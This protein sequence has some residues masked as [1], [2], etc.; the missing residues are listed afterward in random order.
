MGAS[1]NMMTQYFTRLFLA[2]LFLTY[3]L[4]PIGCA[5]HAARVENEQALRAIRQKNLQADMKAM[6][7]RTD[8]AHAGSADE[9]APPAI[10]G[11]LTLEDAIS[12]ALK[13]NLDAAVEELRRDIQEEAVV[14]AR[15]KMLPSLTADGK[16]SRRDSY[17]ASSS[18]PLFTEGAQAYN[19]S[20]DKRTEDFRL[21]LSW[22]LLDFGISYYQYRQDL[23][24]VSIAEQRRRRVIQ[25]LKFNVTETFWLAQVSKAAMQMAANLASRLQ[26]RESI[27]ADQLESRTVS[28]IDVLE[29]AAA[30]SEMNMRMSRF[31]HELQKH[32]H[33]L[34]SLMGMRG[35][36]DFEVAEADFNAPLEK[37]AFR[38]KGL[39][40]TA[41]RLRPELFE[42][43]LEELITVDDARIAVAKM[44]PSASIFWRF[45][46]DNDSHLYYNDWQDVGFKVSFDL[47]SVPEKMSRR[48]EVL[49]T[50]KLIR[51]RR[52]SL[53]AAVL[54]QVNIAL[55]NYEEA[56]RKHGQTKDIGV[57]RKQLM[58]AHR[59][60]AKLG[61]GRIEDVLESEARY[62]FSQERTLS[63][64]AD[65]MIA[66]QR[67]LNT[68]GCDDTQCAANLREKASAPL[69]MQAK[70]DVPRPKKVSL[71]KDDV[72]PEPRPEPVA[73]R[74]AWAPLAMQAKDDV[75]HSKKVSL[76]KDGVA[77]EPRPEPATSGSE[78]EG[79]VSHISERSG[80]KFPYSLHMSSWR[81]TRKA[82]QELSCY[83]EKGLAPF[84]VKVDLGKKGVWWG[85]YIGHYRT[86]E[87]AVNAKTTFKLPDAI[88][89]KKLFANLVGIYSNKDA[90][91][92]LSRKLKQLGYFSYA[93]QGDNNTS[94]LLTGAFWDR[95]RAEKQTAE[96]RL[97]GIEARLT[98]K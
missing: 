32:K 95:K 44:A 84:A 21:E 90:M 64:Y 83:R 26:E 59:R 13:Y 98:L 51:K 33:K 20:R 1:S 18:D 62:L 23:N 24:R 73:S 19:Y 80:S 66:K 54:T 70:D 34:A 11:P 9:S 17:A 47:L 89:K 43:D 91:R 36:V 35:P 14:G 85:I 28:E 5:R 72:A 97:D 78:K 56:I 52:L 67:I 71:A 40:A 45:N 29:T 53:A 81:S 15:L 16:L 31:E 55:V 58:E 3:S 7:D 22:D 27:L 87:D 46:Y 49:K 6:R 76:A 74:K 2:S 68:I 69:P 12:Y 25:N 93:T 4:A 94:R 86:R 42:Q 30:L 37:A 65:V 96:L 79:D 39:E 50:K 77:Q 88:V 38:V 41:L 75:A 8:E 92:D 61:K 57:K 48:R 82:R 60:H 10:K 63:S